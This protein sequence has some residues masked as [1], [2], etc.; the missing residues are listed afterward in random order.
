MEQEEEAFGERLEGRGKNR[1]PN[2]QD[3]SFP[4]G[5]S[6][7]PFYDDVQK[8]T[9]DENNFPD[10]ILSQTRNHAMS[11]SLIR[12]QRLMYHTPRRQLWRRMATSC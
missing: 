2:S 11:D 3:C 7:K 4:S 1:R 9:D 12:E 10:K 5:A 8:K 6:M